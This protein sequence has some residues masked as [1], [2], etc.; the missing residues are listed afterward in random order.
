MDT[1]AKPPL[2]GYGFWQ[3][4]PRKAVGMAPG[5]LVNR[6]NFLSYLIEVGIALWVIY[7]RD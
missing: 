2:R 5:A 7:E 4:C 6:Y 3:T 1:L